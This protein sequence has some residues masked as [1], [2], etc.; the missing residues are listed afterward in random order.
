MTKIK[1]IRTKLSL[2]F[3]S[4]LLIVCIGLGTI[5]YARSSK[6]LIS[7]VDESLYELANKAAMIV[8]ERVNTHLNSLEVAAETDSVRLDEKTLDEKLSLLKKEVERSS[9]L[10]IGI[11]D[12][13]GNCTITNGESTNIYERDYFIKAMTGE[14]LVTD[15]IISKIDGSITVIYAVPIKNGNTIKGILF[16][17]RDGNELSDIVN[18]IKFGE[19]GDAVMINKE[20]TKVAHS[21][22]TLVL[23]MDNDFDNIIKDNGLKSLVELEKQMV[24]GKSGTGEYE[25]NGITKY[26]AYVPVA[27]TNWS[28]ALT[29]LKSDVM[30]RVHDL[31]T[32]IIIVS[33]VFIVISIIITVIISTSISKPIKLVSDYLQLL[34]TGDF[35]QKIHSKMLRMND[36]VGILARATDVMQQSLGNLIRDVSNESSQVSQMLTQISYEIVELNKS[37]EEITATTEELSASTEETASATEEM[38]A[39]SLEIENAVQSVAMKSQEGAVTAGNLNDMADDMK[40]GAINSKKNAIEI[41]EKTKISMENAILQSKSVEQINVLSDAIL[42]IASQTNLL[43]LNAAIEAAR[44]GTAGKGFAVVADEIRSLAVN[45]KNTVVRIQEVTE[46]ILVAV[47]NL[48]SSAHEIMNFI[49]SK[50]LNDYDTL[51]DSS[52][53][54]SLNSSKINDM[55]TDFSSASEEILVSIQSM[56]AALNQVASASTEGA[57]GASS[58]AQATTSIAHMSSEVSNLSEAAKEKSNLLIE[59]VSKLKV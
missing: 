5:T 44:A 46:L 14:K 58:I 59:A 43:A 33:L 2:I 42:E 29:S 27:G 37:I 56:V 8:Q 49:D 26:M 28:L 32:I 7:Q 23:K 9:H 17:A 12:E 4:L 38:N 50:V 34:S 6:A 45:S 13:L 16:A 39:T 30:E 35:T 24:E 48:S 54:Y 11:A 53:L 52:E 57:Q 47:N 22:R 31:T 19:N 36:E 21:N 1:S 25:Y 40:K 15:P 20:G 18:D 3:S 51:V 55:V 41:Y 10:Y